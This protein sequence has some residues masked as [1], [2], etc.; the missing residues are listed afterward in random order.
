MNRKP[1]SHK[2]RNRVGVA[3]G[4]AV[5]L[6]SVTPASAQS[7]AVRAEVARLGS[8]YASATPGSPAQFRIHEELDKLHAMDV[9][10][11]ADFR[12]AEEQSR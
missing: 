1:S 6:A 9:P 11:P 10:S 3:F 2:N 7:R 4:I 12:L 8:L 5:L